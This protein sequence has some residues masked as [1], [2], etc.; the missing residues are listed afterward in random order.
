MKT[1]FLYIFYFFRS[2]Y[3]RGLFKTIRLLRWEGR[4]EKIF[5]IKTLQIK[6]SDDKDNFH[7]QGASYLILLELLKKLPGELKNKI[8][9]DYG[10]GKGRVLFCAEFTGFNNLLGV[11]LDK[12]LIDEAMQNIKTYSKKRK[13]SKFI[14]VHQNALDFEIPNEAQV[15]FFFNPFSDNIMQKVADN[16][17]RSFR[18]Y[19]RDIYIVYMNPQFKEVWSHKGFETFFT[20][21]NSRYAEAIIFRLKD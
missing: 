17:L 15:F 12:E 10:S 2:V 6:K 3:Y 5:N 16:I 21:G 1:V 8:F 20:D 13:E 9:V 7:Y 19:E 11:E 18:S 4:Y 14:F